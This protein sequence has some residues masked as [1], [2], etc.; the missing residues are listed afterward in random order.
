LKKI[1]ALRKAAGMTQQELGEAI[2][3]SYQT[4]CMWERGTTHPRYCALVK[5]CTYFGCTIAELLAEE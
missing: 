5:L 2:G 4:I 3:V 1:K